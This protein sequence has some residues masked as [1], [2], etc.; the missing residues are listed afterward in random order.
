MKASEAL[1]LGS[2]ATKQG[3]GYQSINSPT[4]PCALGAI[5]LV[6]GCMTNSGKETYSQLREVFPLLNRKAQC[7]DPRHD[8]CRLQYR[9]LVIEQIWHLNDSHGW[10]RPQIAEWLQQLEQEDAVEPIP[11][12]RALVVV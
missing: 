6:S 2:V 4:Q 9:T 8:I 7:P 12:E 3:F 1:L 11:Q 5:A 10:T